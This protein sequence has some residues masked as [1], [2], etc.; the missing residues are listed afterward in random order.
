MNHRESNRH[1]DGED[2]S[3]MDQRFRTQLINSMPG[4][5]SVNLVGTK[6]EDGFENLAIFNSVFHV[7]ANPPFLGLVV[8]PDSVDRHTWEN[9]QKTG[10]YSLSQVSTDFAASAHQTS[11]RY[12]KE[13]SEFVEVGFTAEYRAG[14]QAPV[15]A[16]SL[17]SIGLSYQEHHRV[18]AN[19]TLVVIGKI[20]QLWIR[21]S[22][23]GSDGFVDLSKGNVLS[24]IGLDAYCS[25]Q[26]L[27]RF[28]Y[29]KPD[30]PPRQKLP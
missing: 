10:F 16:E 26:L 12:A 1:F 29:A 4:I 7:G 28:E 23:I 18:A 8:R 13:Q 22:L 20:E 5:K 30:L 14:F 27:Q 17:V 3:S 2:F 21:E 15:V 24:C 6:S 19:N 9:I 25:S 11:A